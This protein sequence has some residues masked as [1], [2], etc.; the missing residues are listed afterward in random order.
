VPWDLLAFVDRV[1][2][3]GNQLRDQRGK[4][5][6]TDMSNA[7]KAVLHLAKRLSRL[8]LVVFGALAVLALAIGAPS[9]ASAQSGNC[10]WGLNNATTAWGH[11][12]EVGQRGYLDG[13]RLVVNCYYYPQRIS[14]GTAGQ[15]IY[16]SCPGWSHVTWEQAQPWNG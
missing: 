6:E 15:S 4:N 2:V 1:R 16:A 10:S 8:Q 13:F 5:K 9:P 3:P 14:Y 11:C 12:N 7:S